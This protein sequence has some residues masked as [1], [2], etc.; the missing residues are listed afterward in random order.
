[1]ENN[2]K[3]LDFLSRLNYPLPLY[4]RAPLAFVYTQQW[5]ALVGRL[6]HRGNESEVA[7]KLAALSATLEQFKIFI[8][9]K[10]GAALL[11]RIIIMELYALSAKLSVETCRRI[12]SLL[13]IVDR[14]M[15]PVPKSKMEDTFAPIAAGPVKALSEEVARQSSIQGAPPEQANELAGRRALLTALVEFARRMNFNT[16]IFRQQ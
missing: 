4:C 5:N 15:I 1:M 3:E 12:E 13:G 10:D 9:L 7:E 6:E 14:F 2:E 8:D 11:E 16:D